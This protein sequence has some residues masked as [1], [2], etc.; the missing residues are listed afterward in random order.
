M[1]VND[2]VF[3]LLGGL[4]RLLGSTATPRDEL[5]E[6]S[7]SA[8]TV[9]LT[10]TKG[11]TSPSQERQNPEARQVRGRCSRAGRFPHA[12][13]R[14]LEAVVSRPV[15]SASEVSV[16]ITTVVGACGTVLA[17]LLFLPQARR[18]WANRHRPDRLSGISVLGQVCVLANAAVWGLYAILADA[19]W[20][21]AP[22]FINAPLALVTI[23][24]LLRGRT[25]KAAPTQ[26][27]ACTAG[28]AHRIFVTS[29]P[30]WGSVMRC[31][32]ASRP[33]GVVIFCQDE[34]RTLR[35]QRRT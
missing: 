16:E 11:A 12:L 15:E 25:Q 22:G 27:P 3:Y 32:P 5:D 6:P 35:A 8:A 14:Y 17:F 21:G 9:H 19:F 34:A 2:L 13:A 24:V 31:T 18:T 7:G 30:G 28:I 23:V 1:F 10:V 33:E 4:Q 29:P 20:T 26:C